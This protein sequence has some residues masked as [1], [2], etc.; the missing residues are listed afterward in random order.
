MWQ[1]TEEEKAAQAA[2]KA[3]QALREAKQ[4]AANQT[5]HFAYFRRRK[6]QRRECGVGGDCFFH[7]VLFLKIHSGI[8]VDMYKTHAALR[9]QVVSHLKTHMDDIK[10]NGQPAQIILQPRGSSWFKKMSKVHEYIEYEVIS[11]LAHMIDQVIVVY[12]AHCKRPLV[13]YCKN[14]FTRTEMSHR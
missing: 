10:V 14:I 4:M 5:A 11:A 6:W 2:E 12:S 9:K 8:V 7:T 1:M 3:V 13:R